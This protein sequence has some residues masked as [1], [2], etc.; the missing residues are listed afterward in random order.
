MSKRAKAIQGYFDAQNRGDADAVVRLFSA[1]ATVHNAAFPPVSG[2]HGVKGFCENLY[3]R[4][5]SRQFKVISL[6]EGEDLALAE[7]QVRMKFRPG[8]VLGPCT[9]AEGFDVE[10]RGVNKFEFRPDCNLI[11]CLRVYHET[12]TVARLAAERAKKS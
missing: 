5:S 2:H 7:W 3:A 8:A 1:D 9:L 4:T 6:L 11:S 12:S 10:L